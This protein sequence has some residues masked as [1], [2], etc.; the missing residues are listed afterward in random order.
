MSSLSAMR[1]GGFPNSAR[2]VV[3]VAS[4][5]Q[6]SPLRYPGGKT[7]LIPHVEAW[8]RRHGHRHELLLE[9]FCGGG[10]VS[11]SSVMEDWVGRCFMAEID[12]DVAAFWHAVRK[13][14]P[15][16]SRMVK[17]FKISRE[18]VE[19]LS[20][21][22]PAD[23]LEHGFR[24]LVLNRTRHG[25]ILAPGATFI[26]NGENGKGLGSR[27]Y[28]E[29][30]ANRIE[31]ISE[32]ADRILFMEG[33]GMDLLELLLGTGDR[34]IAVFADPPYIAGGKGAG[35]RLYAHHNVDHGK[36][37][38]LLNDSSAEFLM[39]YADEQEI[40]D[41]I[42]KHKFHA[43]RVHMKNRHQKNVPELIITPNPV[44]L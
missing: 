23:V 12:R 19:L 43:V 3:N 44:L 1:G 39:T 32:H 7:W 18:G 11:L 33:N 9:P 31:A 4:V 29:T 36:L 2:P 25:G 34:S 15:D 13:H 17:E 42:H 37:F 41:L 30:I 26:K 5:P 8:L 38:G 10:V 24:T 6:R 21:R 35:R 27:W 22:P 40:V 20:Q 16:L 14:G 28:P